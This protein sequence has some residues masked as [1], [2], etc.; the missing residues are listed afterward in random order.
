MG[1]QYIVYKLQC[2][3]SI[4]F[5]LSA[6]CIVDE[7]CPVGIG[8]RLNKMIRI[9]VMNISLKFTEFFL[10]TQNCQ[11]IFLLFSFIFMLKLDELFRDQEIFTI[12]S[13]STGQIWVLR[14]LFFQI[15][16]DILPL[17]PVDPDPDP[18]H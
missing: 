8:L 1:K 12:F 18:K 13:F 7:K 17:G 15:L 9:Q 16:I 11:I 4:K 10:T 2:L 5:T 3:G 6:K 14:V